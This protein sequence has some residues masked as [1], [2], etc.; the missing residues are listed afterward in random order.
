[1]ADFAA[2]GAFRSESRD[3]ADWKSNTPGGASRALSALD[4]RGLETG[5]Q[6]GIRT[7]SRDRLALPGM[8]DY[9][10]LRIQRAGTDRLPRPVDRS[11]GEL[12]I[13]SIVFSRTGRGYGRPGVHRMRSPRPAGANSYECS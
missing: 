7:R 5:G 1:M 4:C 13:L 10:W 6:R 9:R 3:S 2:F 8:I 11:S 12:T